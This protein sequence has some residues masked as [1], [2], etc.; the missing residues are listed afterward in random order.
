MS[1]QIL[2]LQGSVWIW[3]AGSAF[4]REILFSDLSQQWRT[5]ALTFDTESN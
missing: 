2:L 4:P 3:G 5:P 1:L